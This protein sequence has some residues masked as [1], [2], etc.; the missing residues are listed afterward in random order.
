MWVRFPPGALKNMRQLIADEEFIGVQE[1]QANL[2]KLLKGAKKKGKLIRIMKFNKPLGFLLSTK[3]WD[4]LLEDL[5]A[6]SS[7]S[8][9]KRIARS[10]ASKKRYSS[11]E[12]KKELGIL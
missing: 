8:F 1:A 9:L 11:E 4:S 12:V 3:T 2:T 10:R 7:D 6:L 5:E